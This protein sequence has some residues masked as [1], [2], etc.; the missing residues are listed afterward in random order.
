MTSVRVKLLIA[1][2]ILPVGR[3]GRIKKNFVS[4]TFIKKRYSRY[5]F[6]IILF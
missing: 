6:L 3:Q 5:N 1:E 2:R 4:R